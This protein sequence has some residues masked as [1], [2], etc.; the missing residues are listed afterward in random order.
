MVSLI[1]LEKKAPAR[2]LSKNQRYIIAPEKSSL[3]KVFEKKAKWPVTLVVK[4]PTDN[5]PAIFTIP[6]TKDRIE[7][8]LRLCPYDLLLPL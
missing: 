4:T 3:T 6:A 2:K 8:S 7:A 1:R 5:N